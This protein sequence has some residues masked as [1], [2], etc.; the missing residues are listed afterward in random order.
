MKP[1]V[2]EGPATSAGS[3]VSRSRA[4]PKSANLASSLG[5]IS[6]FSGFTSRC[7]YV[8]EL[9]LVPVPALSCR[10]VSARST[11]PMYLAA[12][13]AGKPKDGESS[14]GPTVVS[15]SNRLRSV[16]HSSRRNAKNIG[17]WKACSRRTMKGCLANRKAEASLAAT[18]RPFL[19]FWSLRANWRD[20]RCADG[21]STLMT[22]A[23]PPLPNS[24]TR[25]NMPNGTMPLPAS[26]SCRARIRIARTPAARATMRPLTEC[27]ACG[28]GVSSSAASR[29]NSRNL[30]PLIGWALTL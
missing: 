21:N 2:P 23:K 14:S 4:K 12:R 1:K 10:Y 30:S 17:V 11:C 15:Q 27:N 24:S 22:R 16:G 3:T 20:P 13:S 28:D 25:C 7:T 5:E 8:F 18:C 19:F 6:T 26:S 9:A 29:N